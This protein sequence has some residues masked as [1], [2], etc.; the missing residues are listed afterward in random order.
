MK[1]TKRKARKMSLLSPISSSL[2]SE[3][4]RKGLASVPWATDPCH[5]SPCLVRVTER[6]RESWRWSL[7]ETF[8]KPETNCNAIRPFVSAAVNQN[9]KLTVVSVANKSKQSQLNSRQPSLPA[10]C[11]AS[12]QLEARLWKFHV[13]LCARLD[14]EG[15]VEFI[16][17]AEAY[18]IL[19]MSFAREW[20]WERENE[21]E[22]IGRSMCVCV[23]AR[24]YCVLLYC[25]VWWV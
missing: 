3:S 18:A 24:V 17:G 20:E 16:I 9:I 5:P 2:E 25:V 4:L 6:E 15:W 10:T 23:C 1:E 13:R 22:R 19:W 21:N 12:F 11:C 14:D 8:P 7:S